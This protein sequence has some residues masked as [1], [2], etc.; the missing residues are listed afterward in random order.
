M[1]GLRK[2]VLNKGDPSYVWKNIQVKT[3][4]FFSVCGLEHI[5]NKVILIIYHG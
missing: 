4:S 2:E 5:Y 3:F 1:A